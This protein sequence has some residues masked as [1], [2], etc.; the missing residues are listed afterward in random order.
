MRL[1]LPYQ[2]IRRALP[3]LFSFLQAVLAM[4]LLLPGIKV[5]FWVILGV[6][7]IGSLL[8]AI[9][10]WEYRGVRILVRALGLTFISLLFVFF[11]LGMIWDMANGQ[12]ITNRTTMEN[13]LFHL[14]NICLFVQG[15][16]VLFIPAISVA[17]LK[18]EKPDIALYWGLQIALLLFAACTLFVIPQRMMEAD[19]FHDVNKTVFYWFQQNSGSYTPFNSYK[20]TVIVY[21][22]TVCANLLTI[23][24][25]HP[26]GVKRIDRWIQKGRGGNA[27]TTES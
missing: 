10:A 18:E 27:P 12:D 9:Y 2:R 1:N 11:L 8:L 19:F 13:L 14:V 22:A 17:S 7:S 25:R 6:F 5:S 4:V 23:Y 15:A 21:F 20:V 3:V 24:I 16:V 26:F